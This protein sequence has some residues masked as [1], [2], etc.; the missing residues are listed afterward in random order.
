MEN[1]KQ[2]KIYNQRDDT[3]LLSGFGLETWNVSTLSAAMIINLVRAGQNKHWS[4]PRICSFCIS[5]E[6]LEYGNRQWKSTQ[7]LYFI[8]C[9]FLLHKEIK[10]KYNGS[11]IKLFKALSKIRRDT[12]MNSFTPKTDHNL[13]S[14]HSLHQQTWCQ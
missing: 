1:D 7:F 4:P 6:S 10:K 5:R 12:K 13:N 14:S 9:I 11:C 3:C 2:W 8:H